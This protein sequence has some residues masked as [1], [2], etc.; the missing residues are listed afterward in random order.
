M[1]TCQS[2]SP[3]FEARRPPTTFWRCGCDCPGSANGTLHRPVGARTTHASQ[4]WS[5]TYAASS[6]SREPWP[7][8]RS[9][10]ARQGH[11]SGT[12]RS[13]RRRST[14]RAQSASASGAADRCSWMRTGLGSSRTPELRI[15][16][17]EESNGSNT[18]IGSSAPQPSTRAWGGAAVS[19][20]SNRREVAFPPSRHVEPDGRSPTALPVAAGCWRAAIVHHREPRARTGSR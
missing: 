17:G 14:T 13:T 16:Q 12:R 9:C 10:C 8:S 18:G 1:P 6:R 15:A 2:L 4:S 19:L 11:V 20:R 7:R 3:G 5:T